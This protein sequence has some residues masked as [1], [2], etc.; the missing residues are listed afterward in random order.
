MIENFP[1]FDIDKDTTLIFSI[2]WASY[3][4]V[5]IGNVGHPEPD[6]YPE[7]GPKYALVPLALTALVTT[8]LVIAFHNFPF[9]SRYYMVDVF[10]ILVIAPLFMVLD[11]F[12]RSKLIKS[13]QSQGEKKSGESVRKMSSRYI[14]EAVLEAKRV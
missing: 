11:I 12:I 10:S 1:V 14:S 9:D 6:M 5:T 2:I 8:F 13:A 4:I 7:C 3:G